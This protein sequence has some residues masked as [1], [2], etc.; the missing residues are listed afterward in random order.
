M[1]HANPNERKAPPQKQYSLN[2]SKHSPFFD[3]P[4]RSLPCSQQPDV[5]QHPEASTINYKHSHYSFK[6]HFNII[7]HLRVRLLSHVP[8]FDRTGESTTGNSHGIS[9]SHRPVERPSSRLCAA[10]SN[11]PLSSGA[12]TS[13]LRPTQTDLRLYDQHKLISVFTTNTN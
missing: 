10:I 8:I 6:I 4:K 9:D 3:E 11:G 5:G 13:S 2:S 7:P 12:S 1:L